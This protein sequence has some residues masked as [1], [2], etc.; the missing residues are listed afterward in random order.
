M[1]VVAKKCWSGSG[2]H[3]HDVVPCSFAVDIFFDNSWKERGSKNILGPP[4]S[5]ESRQLR[6][7]S[8]YVVYIYTQSIPILIASTPPTR[9]SADVQH[10]HEYQGEKRDEDGRNKERRLL[11]PC[12]QGRG[13]EL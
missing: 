6:V 9:L 3:T 2:D 1:V 7:E 13:Q 10:F 11:C 5:I 4:T 12:Y 8:I